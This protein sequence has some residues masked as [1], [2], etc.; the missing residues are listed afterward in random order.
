M[1]L[2]F[3]PLFKRGK[4]SLSSSPLFGIGIKDK[5]SIFCSWNYQRR[6]WL[7]WQLSK[8]FVKC[9]FLSAWQILANNLHILDRFPL[10]GW[11]TQSV[12]KAWD[13]IKPKLSC[14]SIFYHTVRLL[15]RSDK[16]IL[17]CVGRV[18]T[19][20]ENTTATSYGI[21]VCNDPAYYW[22]RIWI[23]TRQNSTLLGIFR[24]QT[25]LTCIKK[26][27]GDAL[28]FFPDMI[29]M[30]EDTVLIFDLD[31]LQANFLHYFLL[32]YFDYT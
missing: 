11:F 14:S 12:E 18:Y 24:V 4:L 27:F 28:H 8:T 29:G 1:S 22:L 3:H 9:L 16:I 10:P 31:L 30:E 20:T 25:L 32:R 5:H 19:L 13:V 17:I 23:D 6:Q 7:Q 26:T 15:K 21:M 2:V